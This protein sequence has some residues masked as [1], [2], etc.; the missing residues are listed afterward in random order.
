MDGAG[1]PKSTLKTKILVALFVLLAG[2]GVYAYTQIPMIAAGGLLYPM[3]H[4]AGGTAPDG[5]ADAE[6]S[7]AGVTLR[8]WRCLT[9][10]TRPRGTIVYLHGVADNRASAAGALKHF[11]DNGFDA[12]AYDSRAHGDSTGEVCTYGYFEKQDLR[13]VLDSITTPGI[14]LMGHSLGAAVALQAAAE[15]E[16]IDGVVAIESFSDLRTIGRERAFFLPQRLIDQA[17]RYA[18]ER[19]QFKA[20]AVSPVAAAT[21]IHVPVLVIHGKEDDATAPRHSERIFEALAGPKRLLLVDGAQHNQS[22]QPDVWVAVDRWIDQIADGVAA[23]EVE[24]ELALRPSEPV[25]EWINGR[26]PRTLADELAELKIPPPSALAGDLDRNVRTFSHLTWRG[27]TWIAYEAMEGKYRDPELRVGRFDARARTWRTHRV[28]FPGGFEWLSTSGNFVLGSGRVSPSAGLVMVID[29]EARQPPVVLF[30]FGPLLVPGGLVYQRSMI[31]G[32]PTLSASLGWFD[33]ATGKDE[34]LYPQKPYGPIRQAFV[35]RT[36][37]VYDQARASG[38]CEKQH[39]HCDPEAFESGV[40]DTTYDADRLEVVF[41]TS[42]GG[43][44]DG[45]PI[46]G[47]AGAEDVMVSCGPFG[48]DSA[49]TCRERRLSEIV[50]GRATKVELEVRKKFETPY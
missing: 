12:I 40:S 25:Q 2:A 44:F 50:R 16:R 14:V 20:D 13:R 48:G 15:D 42:F 19:G 18:E 1:L 26:P 3:R 8:G 17:F 43:P 22:M 11:I 21:R 31:H 35:E 6:F 32:Q 9:M 30:G 36:R 34:V 39:H 10:T 5:C 41:V 49:P 29:E 28:G 27:A 4:A 7:G 37:K 47:P 24:R 33:A 45:D 38:E 46:D 23:R